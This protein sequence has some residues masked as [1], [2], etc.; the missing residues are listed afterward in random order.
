MTILHLP[1]I[2]GSLVQFRHYGPENFLVKLTPNVKFSILLY[3]LRESDQIKTRNQHRMARIHPENVESAPF[4]T[5]TLPRGTLYRKTC[6]L[7]LTLY[8]LGSD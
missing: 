3:L 1:N 6:V 4:P 8:F 2:F 5:L 7:F